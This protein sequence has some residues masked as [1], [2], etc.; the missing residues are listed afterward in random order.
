MPAAEYLLGASVHANSLIRLTY[1]ECLQTI[2]EL[3]W[4]PSM[5][6][7]R[8]SLRHI[9]LNRTIEAELTIPQVDR[10]C[11][12]SFLAQTPLPPA[13]E[14]IRVSYWRDEDRWAIADPMPSLP[15]TVWAAGGQYP[16]GAEAIPPLP[17][18]PRSP[19]RTLPPIT[20]PPHT[21]EMP[22]RTFEAGYS[23]R[24]AKDTSGPEPRPSY[25]QGTQYHGSSYRLEKEE[26]QER[27]HGFHRPERDERSRSSYG[28]ERDDRAGSSYRPMYRDP[29]ASGP[30]WDSSDR[31]RRRDPP[32][33]GPGRGSSYRLEN[34]ECSSYWLTYREDRASGS[35]SHQGL[36]PGWN[37]DSRG[38]SPSS[39]KS[40]GRSRDESED[41]GSDSRAPK[42]Q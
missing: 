4:C 5:R 41:G 39:G 40:S 2:Q 38:G 14:V 15:N 21:P 23:L 26:H 28:F 34:E 25:H 11:L 17:K 24:D 18:S 9:P 31:P 42:R 22:P 12:H 30:P 10:S 13:V 35:R 16:P 8:L 7:P 20:A 33:S 19:P 27:L 1:Q 32:T 37:Q 36:S 3:L 6:D 29:P